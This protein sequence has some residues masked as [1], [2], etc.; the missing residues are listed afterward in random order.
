MPSW[1]AQGSLL[2]SW[3]NFFF[4]EH[5]IYVLLIVQDITATSPRLSEDAASCGNTSQP[6]ALPKACTTLRSTLPKSRRPPREIKCHTCYTPVCRKSLTSWIPAIILNSSNSHC[7]NILGW[8]IGS[9]QFWKSK[10]MNDQSS[11]FVKGNERAGIILRERT[12]CSKGLVPGCAE[13]HMY[14]EQ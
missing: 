7:I 8:A 6:W 11:H 4:S 2:S 9:H 3:L 12:K 13:I 1:A 14:S 5:M 10:T